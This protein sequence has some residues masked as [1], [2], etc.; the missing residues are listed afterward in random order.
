MSDTEPDTRWDTCGR[1]RHYRLE[2]L[3]GKRCTAEEDSH[4]E[5]GVSD[6]CRCARFITI[7]RPV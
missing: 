2:H 4:D 7:S 5:P 6:R 3:S 1:C